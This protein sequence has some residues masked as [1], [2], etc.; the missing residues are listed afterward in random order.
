MTTKEF[1]NMFGMSVDAMC[2]YTGFSR[3][4]LNEIVQRRSTKPG[5]KK[6]M[7]CRKLISQSKYI[8]DEEVRAARKR[9]N[10]REV[11]VLKRF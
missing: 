3:D 6:D 9:H 5:A 8:S 10:E 11:A 2:E 4:G 1:A 7:A